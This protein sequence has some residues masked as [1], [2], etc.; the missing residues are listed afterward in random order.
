[1]NDG[2]SPRTGGRYRRTLA[3]LGAL[4]VLLPAAACVPGTDGSGAA[5]TGGGAASAVPDPAKAG[6]VTLTVWDQQVR[7]GQ[8]AAIERLNEEFEK[9]YPNVT[10]KRVA[11]SFNDLKKTLKL[12]LSGEEPPDVVQANQGY[13]DMVA[14]AHAGML[15]PLDNYAGLYGWNTRFPQTLLNLNRVSADGKRF[16]TGRLYGVSQEGEYIGVYYDKKVLRKAGVEPPRTWKEFTEALPRVKKAGQ[17]PVQFGNLDKYPAIHTFGLLQAQAAGSAGPVRETVFGRG[18]GFE[19]DATREAA[20]TLADWSEKGYVPGGAN[21]KGYDD[22]AKQF[23]DGKGAFLVTGT[24][25]LADL[26][27]TMG[28]DLGFMPPP[29]DSGAQPVTTGGEG[30]PWSVTSKS[31]HPEVAAA[32]LDFLTS[33]HASDVLTEE[34]VLPVVP[35][36]AAEKLDPDSAVGRMVAGWQE[37][38]DADGLVPYLDYTTPTFYDTLSADLQGVLA[39][40]VGPAELAS[41]MQKSYDDFR[42]EQRADGED[43]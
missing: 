21:G 17:L 27:K 35:G 28:D 25:Q 38:N 36:A 24:W 42:A 3:A 6:E 30:L 9:K 8:N 5:G 4:C 18:E 1:M 7:G 22:A 11:R 20:R 16:G 15:A 34:G 39:G 13:S 31:D 33:S 29:P 10:I 12:A 26:R 32:Y 19:T 14:F 23:A 41:R 40:D 37:L 43:R 2:R